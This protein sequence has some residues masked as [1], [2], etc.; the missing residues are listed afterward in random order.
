VY[1]SIHTD[2]P[3]ENLQVKTNT[4]DTKNQAKYTPFTIYHKKRKHEVNSAVRRDI[5]NQR[6]RQ[7]QAQN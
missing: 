3:T 7:K 5:Y 4:I 2:K 6:V 1:Y